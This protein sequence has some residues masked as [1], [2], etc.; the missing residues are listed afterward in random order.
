MSPRPL[1][2][3]AIFAFAL[4]ALTA[5]GALADYLEVTRNANVKERPAGDA[6][7]LARPELGTHLQLLDNGEQVNGYY[8]SVLPAGG[9]TTSPVGPSLCASATT[10]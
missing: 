6:R 10:N 1:K 3:I 5:S 7:V 9:G 4:L 8:R 2:R